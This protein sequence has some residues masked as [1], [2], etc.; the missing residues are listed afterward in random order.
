MHNTSQV[1]NYANFT[2]VSHVWYMW[3][4]GFEDQTPNIYVYTITVY[5]TLNYIL[6]FTQEGKLTHTF[7]QK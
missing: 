3:G 7:P 1:V 4:E 5:V 2:K 6:N